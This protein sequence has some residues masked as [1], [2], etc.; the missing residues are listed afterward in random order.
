[1]ASRTA[2]WRL[3]RTTSTEE[4]SYI[5]DQSQAE[6]LSTILMTGM[7][8][9]IVLWNENL[10][11]LVIRVFLGKKPNLCTDATLCTLDIKA[12]NERALEQIKEEHNSK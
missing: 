5:L 2:A 3:T 6:R 10:F 12:F 9:C 4:V 1:V 8:I 11:L 7:N